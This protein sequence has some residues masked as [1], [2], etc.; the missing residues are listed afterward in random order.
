M[1][2]NYANLIKNQNTANKS[3][4]L[5]SKIKRYQY[6]WQKELNNLIDTIGSDTHIRSDWDNIKDNVMRRIVYKKFIMLY[7]FFV[8]NM[9]NYVH[10][11]V[12]RY[13]I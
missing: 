6:N 9:I 13:L 5:A 1:Y 3:R 11:Y 2:N 4:Y 10:Y 12:P 7:K 8:Y